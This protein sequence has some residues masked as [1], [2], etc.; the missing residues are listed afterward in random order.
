MDPLP[1][2]KI[3]RIPHVCM[4]P[5]DI[6]A[7]WAINEQGKIIPKD[8]L[9]HDQSYKGEMSGTSVNSRCDSLSLHLTNTKS[10][11]KLF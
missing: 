11:S 6:Q 5:L 4:A 8:C 9:T 10:G 3:E 1:L 7:Q 2:N